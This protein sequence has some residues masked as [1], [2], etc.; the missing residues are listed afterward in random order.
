MSSYTELRRWFPTAIG[1][2]NAIGVSRETIRRWEA[3]DGAALS[4]R[5][6]RLIANLS[7]TAMDAEDE[8]G[9]DQPRRVGAWMLSPQ[10]SLR[11]RR[12]VD[13]I[14][15]NDL[16]TVAR[17]LYPDVVAPRGE[18]LSPDQAER[19]LAATPAPILGN[20]VARERPRSAEKAAALRR[21]GTRDELIGPVA[22]P[23]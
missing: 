11:G 2:A 4:D 12:V 7:L 3:T 19:D 21:I 8:I 1:R 15:V 5:V 13:L 6:E 22:Q 16:T 9:S 10:P 23:A 14:Q 18:Q 20:W 17:L